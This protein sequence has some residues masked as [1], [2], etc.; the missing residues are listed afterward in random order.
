[1]KFNYP[2]AAER[3]YSA[4]LVL[5]GVDSPVHDAVAGHVLGLAAECGLKALLGGVGILDPHT[6]GI[7]LGDPHR[8][9]IEALWPLT[10]FTL[11]GR[12]G[13]RIASQLP[14]GHPF[15]NYLVDQRYADDTDIPA[16]DLPAWREAT[17]AVMTCLQW[18]KLD[19]LL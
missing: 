3:N 18:A 19:G 17:T 15:A 5:L 10:Q 8:C 9:H 4:A 7:P 2:Q 6:G 14:Q 13:A 16:R 1:M 11:S 12:S